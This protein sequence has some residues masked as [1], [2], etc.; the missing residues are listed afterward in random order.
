MNKS[1]QT[2]NGLV[3]CANWDEVKDKDYEGKD[4]VVPDGV[5]LK[6]WT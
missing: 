2:S 6:S 5:D 3:L 1:M 4:K